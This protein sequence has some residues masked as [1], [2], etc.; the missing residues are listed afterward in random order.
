MSPRKPPFADSALKLLSAES[1]AEL[2]ATLR[3]QLR[4]AAEA[5][6]AQ[7]HCKAGKT[8]K[9]MLID[10]RADRA[11]RGL[12]QVR[13]LCRE[14]I[15][16]IVPT[17]RVST[18]ME[19]FAEV[20]QQVLALQD[21]IEN[22]PVE[23]RKWLGILPLQIGVR[24]LPATESAS[25]EARQKRVEQVWH[26]ANGGG[27]AASMKGVPGPEQKI[28]ALAD[29]AELMTWAEEVLL[30]ESGGE[31]KG[32]RTTFE[33]QRRYPRVGIKHHFAGA[34][35]VLFEIAAGPG[36]AHRTGDTEYVSIRRTP[37]E[38]F[39]KTAN[40]YVTGQNAADWEPGQDVL[41]VVLRVRRVLR[42]VGRFGNESK[43]TPS[44]VKLLHT[45]PPHDLFS[46]ASGCS[47]LG[48]YPK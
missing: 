33:S 48:G 3:Q 45:F 22:M 44:E 13:D 1:E 21:S 47:S 39:M 41:K 28:A 11:M 31:D 2:E 38:A 23:A 24:K 30:L 16:E 14:A 12:M 5:A 19:S 6:L 20:K 10:R 35:V 46:W 42:R 15:E 18:L 17:D 40:R 26:R 37:F 43:L 9:A 25:P 27:F 36:S 7:K 8:G 29:L 32:G 34:C 4:S